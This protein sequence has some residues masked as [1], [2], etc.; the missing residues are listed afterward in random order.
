[1]ELMDICTMRWME[2]DYEE[3]PIKLISMDKD[4]IHGRNILSIPYV[5]CSSISEEP[6]TYSS[7][8]STL[9]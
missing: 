3:V 6:E 9:H 8:N 5:V 2:Y 1:M 4:S 7:P